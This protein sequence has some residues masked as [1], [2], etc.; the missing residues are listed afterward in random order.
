MP[1][2]TC[3]S[4]VRPTK[5]I[6]S[7][8]AVLLVAAGC[9]HEDDEAAVEAIDPGPEVVCADAASGDAA[10]TLELASFQ[11]VDMQDGWFGNDEVHLNV[12]VTSSSGIEVTGSCHV[13]D[14]DK[15][16]TKRQP[17][18]GFHIAQLPRPQDDEIFVVTV[19]GI[20]S[21]NSGAAAIWNAAASILSD[22]LNFLGS[23]R[24]TALTGAPQS[25]AVELAIAVAVTQLFSDGFEQLEGAVRNDNDVVGI[26]VFVVTAEQLTPSASRTDSCEAP[27]DGSETYVLDNQRGEW[28]L[29]VRWS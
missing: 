25:A 24:A 14:I 4:C 10:S 13:D 2:T 17:P 27:P 21:D 16:E 9:D 8:L 5:L 7:V 29:G 11:V 19:V 15:G 20:E 28:V 22:V 18:G 6:V 26:C 23:R 1:S 3:P 12:A